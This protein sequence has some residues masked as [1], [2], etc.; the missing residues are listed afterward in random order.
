[1]IEGEADLVVVTKTNKK[2]SLV[3]RAKKFLFISLT[4][5]LGLSL[6]S[7]MHSH[8]V[9]NAQGHVAEKERALL[10]DSLAIMMIVVLPVIIM[11]IAF[12]LRYRNRH[13]NK[14]KYRPD[15]A[16][17]TLL[18]AVWWGVPTI[19]IVILGVITW[20]TSHSLDPYRHISSEV[21]QKKIATSNN[22][23]AHHLGAKAQSDLTKPLVIQAVSIRWKW[24]FIYPDQGIA[25]VNTI[26]IPKDRPVLFKLTSEAP[27]TAFFIP[28]LG[29]QI[30]VMA[31]MQT[32]VNL[33][34]DKITPKDQPLVGKNAQYNGPGFSWN[35][36]DVN[37]VDGKGF[38]SWV[39]SVKDNTS[40]KSLS[41]PTYVK[42]IWQPLNNHMPFHKMY[43]SKLKQKQLYM[44]IIQKYHLPLADNSSINKDY[45]REQIQKSK[46][47][48]SCALQLYQLS[49]DNPQKL[50][51]QSEH[52]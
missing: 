48:N 2:N 42:K 30:Y 12:A 32:K 40:Y 39:K 7:C 16:H 44:C 6:A 10:F 8:G 21:A 37:V 23:G 46:W 11:S 38:E 51:N 20:K 5:L 18:E 4:V 41:V 1:M 19:I 27:M 34:A 24:L 33:I 15:W 9:L 3:A 45:Y 36:F 29:S 26:T 43:F 52:R 28:Q 14:S 25:T 13:D 31:G 50:I 17:N 22:K 47:K 35:R 49:L